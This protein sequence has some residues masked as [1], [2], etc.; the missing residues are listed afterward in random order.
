MRV[1]NGRRIYSFSVVA[2]LMMDGFPAL[3]GKDSGVFRN[4]SKETR[5]GR[6]LLHDE[7]AVFIEAPS[8]RGRR[9]IAQSGCRTL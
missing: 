5:Y 1:T 4:R 6:I 2:V 9:G 3:D 7:G 8:G